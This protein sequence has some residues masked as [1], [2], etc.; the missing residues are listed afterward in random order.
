VGE[1]AD[2]TAGL[3]D[4]PVRV[5]ED[6]AGSAMRA[7][8]VLEKAVVADPVRAVAVVRVKAGVRASARDV[9]IA[10]G[11]RAGQHVD[12][13]AGRR[14]TAPPVA[15]AGL[16]VTTIGRKRDTSIVRARAASRARR[17][18][19]RNGRIGPTQYGMLDGRAATIRDVVPNHRRLDRSDRRGD[20]QR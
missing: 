7:A 14:E 20:V 10:I 18:S 12:L 9:G 17:V 16:D 5:Q 13:R 8:A 15:L 1:K 2:V 11:H 19:A 4:V 6:V 3:R